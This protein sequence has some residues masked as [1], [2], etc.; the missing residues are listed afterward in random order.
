MNC[1][2]EEEGHFDEE[3]GVVLVE[4]GVLVGVML[5]CCHYQ[6]DHGVPGDIS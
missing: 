1:P 6:P 5:E 2:G 4:A 3:V